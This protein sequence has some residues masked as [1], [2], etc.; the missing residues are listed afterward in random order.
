MLRLGKN[1]LLKWRIFCTQNSRQVFKIVNLSIERRLL[2]L[3]IMNIFY[4]LDTGLST[5]R[6]RHWGEAYGTPRA[7]KDILTI[8]V[9]YGRRALET[10]IQKISP[11]LRT[12]RRGGVGLM[13]G[14]VSLTTGLVRNFRKDQYQRKRIGVHFP[15]LQYIPEAPWALGWLRREW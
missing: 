2:N 7:E 1:I 12:N 13:F 9:I 14:I 4:R 8:C 3:L 10:I 5:L 6:K 15:M 11:K